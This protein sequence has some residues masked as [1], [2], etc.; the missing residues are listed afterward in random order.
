MAE[1]DLIQQLDQAAGAMLA[2]AGEPSPGAGAGPEV[3]E[4]LRIAAMVRDLPAEEFRARLKREV[5]ARALEKGKEEEKQTMTTTTTWIREGFHSITPYLLAPSS[6]RL[7]D[8]LKQAFEGEEMLR[9][10][11]PDGTIMHAQLRIGDSMIEMG[12]DPPPPFAV[13][14]AA[15]HLYVK[16]ADAVYRR[17]LEAGATSTHEP[18]DQAYGDREASVKDPAGNFWY[19]ATNIAKDRGGRYV[20]EGLH[21][22]TP[23]L[24]PHGAPELI[25]FLKRAFGAEEV[26]RHEAPAG[27]V[28]HAMVRIGDSMIEMGEAHGQWQPLP[29]SLHLYVPNVDEMYRRAMD[30]GAT[31]INPP[32]DQPYGDRAAGVIDPH[33]NRWYLATALGA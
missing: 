25:D 13:Q 4:L 31:S 33:G 10:P 1:R 16:D 19:I 7:M 23:F 14:P 26:S 12:E 30:A 17:A 27:T 21:S 29:C 15:L 3:T 18:V 6:A 2:G 5:M 8:F 32:A 20:P 11:R 9:V 24:H 22:V 28:V